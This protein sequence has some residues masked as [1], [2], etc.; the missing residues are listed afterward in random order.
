MAKAPADVYRPKFG[1]NTVCRN[2]PSYDAESIEEDELRQ[3]FPSCM[4][5]YKQAVCI[6]SDCEAVLNG[7]M[8][9]TSPRTQLSS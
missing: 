6:A 3:H 8:I 4:S 7:E 9:T 1:A 5:P 2:C